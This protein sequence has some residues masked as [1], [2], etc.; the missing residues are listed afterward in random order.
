M[1]ASH[2]RKFPHVCPIHAAN[3]T[4]FRGSPGPVA[5]GLAAALVHV[6]RG[7]R[8]QDVEV[9]KGWRGGGGTR[10]RGTPTHPN[11]PR[12]HFQR[13]PGWAQ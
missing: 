9:P 6:A 2:E 5:E 1:H 4:V 13:G 3:P 7:V 11:R 10:S 8:H 12:G